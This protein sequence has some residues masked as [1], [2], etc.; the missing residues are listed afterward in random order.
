ML[1]SQVTKDTSPTDIEK[2]ADEIEVVMKKTNLNSPRGKIVDNLKQRAADMNSMSIPDWDAMW[3]ARQGPAA[4]TAAPVK[5]K[6]TT[7]KKV[8]ESEAE[9]PIDLT[10]PEAGEAV[11]QRLKGAATKIDP[12]YFYMTP[13]NIAIGK[14]WMALRRDMGVV[15]NMLVVGPSGCGKTEGLKRLAEEFQIPFYKVDCGSITTIDR[16]VGHKEIVAGPNGPET[17]YVLS[18]FLQWISGDGFEPGLVDLDEINRLHPQLLNIVIPILDGSQS[19]WVPDLGVRVPVH[20][21]TMIAA[22]A[23]LGVGYSGTHGMDIAL[24]DRFGVVMEQTFPPIPEEVAIL[25]RRTGLDDQRAQTLVTVATQARAKANQG[26]VSKFVSTRA[27]IDWARWVTTGMSMTD[28]AEA[29]IVKKFS[30]DGGSQ[31]ERA[32]LRLIVQGVCAGK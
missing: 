13:Q 7:A 1:T 21:G 12:G 11:R 19:I 29:T 22:T 20:P 32:I 6:R 10:A 4:A 9:A 5:A 30:E 31:S 17:K 26:E 28:A 14:T 18:E 3:A 23:N 8:A 15:M 16:W 25:T 27:L 24:H 2:I